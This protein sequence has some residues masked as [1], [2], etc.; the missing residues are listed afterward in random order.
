MSL[1]GKMIS[2]ALVSATV[3]GLTVA[4]AVAQ[5]PA[6][7]ATPV[8]P[9]PTTKP[10]TPSATPAAPAPAVTLT[11]PVLPTLNTPTA[12]TPAPT[13]PSATT[14][15][16]QEISAA[17]L[18][19]AKQVAK[20]APAIGD[21]DGILPDVMVDT[22]TR[23]I[24]LRPDLYQ[25]ISKTVETTASML[26]VRRA[27]L[28]NDVARVWAR[29]FTDDELKAINAFFSSPVGV[30]YKTVA[31][32]VGNDIVQA[33]QNW[34]DRLSN[35]MFDLSVAALQKQGFQFPTN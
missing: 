17:R 26:V 2:G 10:A 21:F 25:Q 30:K 20:S 29:A 18:A 12:S 32:Q 31:P 4:A 15:V 8:V 5:T 24:N 7:P 27:D 13:A 6:K 14:A 35:E 33:G 22:K 3:L 1:V 28:D 19:L 11:P 9:T 34:A 23:L 16:P